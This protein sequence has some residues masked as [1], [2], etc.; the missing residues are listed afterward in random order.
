MH[1]WDV[2][3]KF[4]WKRFEVSQNRILVL[5]IRILRIYDA[6]VVMISSVPVLLDADRGRKT[7]RCLSVSWCCSG[8]F[9]RIFLPDPFGRTV[10]SKNTC[11]AQKVVSWNPETSVIKNHD[12][13]VLQTNDDL[14]TFKS[15]LCWR[16]STIYA[17]PDLHG[18]QMSATRQISQKAL[19]VMNV[20]SLVIMKV[21]RTILFV[22]YVSSWLSD[23]LKFRC[24]EEAFL[25]SGTCSDLVFLS[26]SFLKD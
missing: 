22:R 23:V 8:T 21:R 24:S 6:I 2:G 20:T 1:L 5:K 15:S 16:R 17:H 13:R 26:Y 9:T 18:F 12:A 10:T 11:P 14:R 4:Y 25:G 3:S 7:R 19:S